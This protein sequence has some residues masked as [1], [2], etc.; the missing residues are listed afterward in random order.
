MADSFKIL[1]VGSGPDYGGGTTYVLTLMKAL[2]E[3]YGEVCYAGTPGLTFDAI[4]SEGYPVYAVPALQRE[5]NPWRDGMAMLQLF[6]IMR[7]H[8]FDLVHTH[9]SKGGFLGRLAA[10]MAGT[11]AILHT[12]HG[13][14]FHEMTPPLRY[15]LY[16]LL[17]KLAAGCCDR[18]I[19]VNQ[20]DRQKA[21]N[22]G[23][24]A[25]EK[26]LTIYNGIDAGRFNQVYQRDRLRH[27]L[28]T[29]EGEY[30]VGMVA[31]LAPSKA[32]LDFIHAAHH[33]LSCRGDVKF[34]LV[35]DG[36]LRGEIEQEI[37][38]LGLGKRVV[39]TGFRTDIPAILSAMDVFVL[40]TLWEGMPIAALE[41][42]AMGKPVISTMVRG[43]REVVQ[44]GI[45]GCLVPPR[46]PTAVGEAILEVIS[47]P[48]MAAEMG[49]RGRELVDE[50]FN[51]S[52]MTE[53]TLAVYEE[54]LAEK[55]GRQNQSGVSG[56]R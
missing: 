30:L 54:L 37:E 47:Q 16:I 32:P 56:C 49:R 31:R 46:D 40:T 17:E 45:T 38:R 3:R 21:V 35:G 42:M 39:L 53:K 15:G 26:I 48:G 22:C 29:A 34:V 27:E 7:R 36:P 9:T 51:S 6:R 41:A 55:K 25:P 18:I 33:V 11:P 43:P 4:Q 2:R 5:I 44:D 8:R 1:Q 28:G 20:E 13:F 50:V 52:R 24:A 14:A 12:V 19:S 23:I 10:R